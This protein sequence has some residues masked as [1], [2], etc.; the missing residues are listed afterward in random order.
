MSPREKPSRVS[1]RIDAIRKIITGSN[2]PG[3]YWIFHESD[4]EAE[5]DDR[6]TPESF[7][8]FLDRKAKWSN[9]T[10]GFGARYEGVCRH[11]EKELAEIRK[12]P[13]DL[14][15]WVD[16]VLLA[17]DGAQRAGFSPEQIWAAMR[18]KQ[19]INQTRKWPAPGGQDETVEHIR[20]EIQ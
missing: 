4:F 3:A 19:R 2:P 20:E 12:D 18:A 16:V 8:D 5:W 10:F 17:L 9:A 7:T 13:D 14:T 1:V 6:P 15:E 11:I